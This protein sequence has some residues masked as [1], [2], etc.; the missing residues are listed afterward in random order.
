MPP[1]PFTLTWRVTLVWPW[2]WAKEQWS[3]H[4]A[5]RRSIPAVPLKLNWLPLM[6]TQ[7][8]CYGTHL[9]VKPQGY[10]PN[11]T[12]L[13]DNQSII[14]LHENGCWSSHKR[15]RHLNIK[16]FFMNDHI[17]QGHFKVQ[18]HPTDKMNSDLLTKPVHGEQAQVLCADI[19]NLPACQSLLN[20]L[21]HSQSPCLCKACQLGCSLNVA[22]PP[23]VDDDEDANEPREHPAFEMIDQHQCP[24]DHSEDS[25]YWEDDKSSDES[26]V[27][28]AEVVH[29]NDP[30]A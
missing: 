26:E 20:P 10:E 2:P 11:I 3:P 16:Y 17:E 6:T 19:M 30:R 23:D 22:L 15:T 13:Q 7:P 24:S 9:F 12:V 14:K 1:S 27:T 29:H 4:P 18:Y 21:S 25:P 5:S 28:T 8:S